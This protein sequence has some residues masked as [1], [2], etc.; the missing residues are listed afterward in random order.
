[1]TRRRLV[2]LAALL[3]PATASGQLALERQVVANGGG[4]QEGE[5]YMIDAT[6]GQAA[7]GRASNT[8]FTAE[9]GFWHFTISSSD[10]TENPGVL[11]TRYEL[12]TRSLGAP[13]LRG[14][15]SFAVPLRSRIELRLYDVTG[16]AVQLLASGEHEAGWHEARLESRGLPSGM[17]FCRLTADG[18]AITRRVMLMR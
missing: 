3:V 4:T 5:D 15:I 11:P 6:C 2:L 1:M 8:S 17:Y 12:G 10:V 16:R 18:V 9:I 13:A 7:V 14:R